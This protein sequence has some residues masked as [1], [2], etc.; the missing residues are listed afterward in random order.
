MSSVEEKITPRTQ[1]P[2]PVDFMAHLAARGA[3]RDA[4]ATDAA[5]TPRHGEAMSAPIDWSALTRLTASALA[6]E[7]AGFY[8]CRRV[9]RDDL[10]QSRFAGGDMSMRFLREGRLFPYEDAGGACNLAVAAPIDDETLRSIEIA[11]RK[12][13]A[14]AAA[15]ADDIDAALSLRS[16]ADQNNAL[17][18]AS[19]GAG[20]DDLDNLRDLARG[21]PVVRALDDLLRLAVEQR[22]TDL[23]IE[24]NGDGL[25]VRLRIDGMLKNVPPPPM[26]MAKGILS[27][28]KILAGL[29]IIERRLAQDGR[30]HI[31]VG[32]SEIDLR[33]ATMPTMH[34][35][36]AV[37]RLLR[38]GSGLVA[39][40]QIGLGPRD[41]AILR[42]ALL[43]PYGMII[44]TG[45]T[46][47]GKTTTLAASLAVINEPTRKILTIEDPVEYQIPGI[48][49]TQVH[50]AI[51]LTFASALRSFMRLDPDVIMVGEMRDSETAHI[52]VHAALTGHLVLTT[53]HTNT[54]AGAITR[55][56]DM[57]IE[58]FLL[59][60]SARVI[61]GQ[62]LVRILCDHCKEP[63]RLTEAEVGADERYAA[64]GIAPGEVVCRPKGCEWCG[65][66]GFR[67]RKGVFEIMEIGPA[68]RRAI[69]PKTD[70]SEL[71]A[72]ARREGMSTMTEDGIVKLRA[73]QTTLDEIF[74]LTSSL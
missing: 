11:L 34:G 27:R 66:T 12:P 30:A 8:G 58:S 73:G 18:Q 35:E 10:T 29:N 63:H 32:G 21:A 65:F 16:E 67:G 1:R 54:A 47:S 39:L 70:A 46:G 3:L 2:L 74:R 43:A 5:R 69:G 51:G 52:G 61:V 14:L 53:L 40:N 13:I 28:L 26:S 57:G 41:E 68:L 50:P 71:E 45:P 55:M 31:A 22:A 4:Q 49:Q 15:T 17:P 44:V 6:D 72:A 37:I 20:E 60:S 19:A 23:H 9:K 24:P 33:V 25:Q 38:K 56:I 7:L 59:A 62:R 64:L 36:C 48:N 42:K